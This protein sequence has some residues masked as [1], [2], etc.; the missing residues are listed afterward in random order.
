MSLG[1]S[2]KVFHE[3]GYGHNIH[4]CSNPSTKG[5]YRAWKSDHIR[6]ATTWVRPPHT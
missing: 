6:T 5:D 3:A 1:N 4:T 2:D